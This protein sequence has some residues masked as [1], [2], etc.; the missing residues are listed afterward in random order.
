M[1]KLLDKIKS[2][3]MYMSLRK[4]IFWVLALIWMIII[5]SLSGQKGE[6]SAG[7]SHD[8]CRVIGFVTQY[9]FDKWTEDAQ[10]R[11]I[12]KLQYPV[13]KAAHFTEYMILA[14]LLT[15]AWYDENKKRLSGFAVPALIGII[16]AATDEFHQTFISGRGGMVKDVMIDSCGVIAGVLIMSG[17]MSLII[18]YLND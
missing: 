9:D 2:V 5:F 11:Y 12:E 3:I 7:L 4:K 15:G 6:E 18:K 13:R 1:K 16:Y 10:E 8:I 17:I 14:G